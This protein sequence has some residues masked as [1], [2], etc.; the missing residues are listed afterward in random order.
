[1]IRRLDTWARNGLK[2]RGLRI[3][4]INE[5][6]F[7]SLKKRVASK[8]GFK[9]GS[10]KSNNAL[11]RAKLSSHR[12]LLEPKDSLRFDLTGIGKKKSKTKAH[13][14]A[15]P[16][17]FEQAS[18][19]QRKKTSKFFG[20][21]RLS[22][23]KANSLLGPENGTLSPKRRSDNTLVSNWSKF[24]SEQVEKVMKQKIK[25]QYYKIPE[26]S[27]EISDK[28]IKLCGDE[29]MKVMAQRHVPSKEK[30]PHKAIKVM[31]TTELLPTVTKKRLGIDAEETKTESLIKRAVSKLNMKVK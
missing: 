9:R 10:S 29:T 25:V 11:R 12:I 26:S 16:N 22:S 3:M 20:E 23:E 2:G 13:S 8:L 18:A 1:M 30:L 15:I 21:P 31:G 28:F 17:S 19:S 4:S 14:E 27:G 7:K 6:S 5:F 24:R